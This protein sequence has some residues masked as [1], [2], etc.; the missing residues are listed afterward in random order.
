[1][2]TFGPDKVRDVLG[3]TLAWRALQELPFM[4]T[5][6]SLARA[7]AREGDDRLARRATRL[8]ARLGDVPGCVPKDV[9][10]S[11]KT[12]LEG[13]GAGPDHLQTLGTA[14]EIG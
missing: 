10:E 7:H 1:M 8:L 13:R 12:S 5:T 4:R 3:V 6:L 11:M 14:T 2:R 9:F